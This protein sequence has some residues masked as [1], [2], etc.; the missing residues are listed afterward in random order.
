[1]APNPQMQVVKEADGV[2]LFLSGKS[3]TGYKGARLRR[4]P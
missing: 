2:K 3:N 4:R 1:M